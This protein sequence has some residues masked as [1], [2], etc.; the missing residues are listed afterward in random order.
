MNIT[1]VVEN[2]NCGGLERMVIELAKAQRAAGHRCQVVCVFERGTLAVELD[3]VG[4]PVTACG[5]RRGLDLRAL[6]R[7]RRAVAGHA[8]QIL[9]TH[10]A[11]AHYLAVLA[12]LG[13]PIARIINT[14]HGMAVSQAMSRRE[15][16]YHRAL[17][18]T[19][20]VAMVCAAARE[21][22]V[23]HGLVP[24]RLAHVVPNGIRIEAFA[25]ADA[26]SRERLHETLGLAPGARV[27]GTVGR[28]NWAKN[29]VSLIRAFARVQAE[30]ADAVLVLVGAGRLRQE[31]EQCARAEGVERQVHFLGARGDVRDLLPGFDVF[32][33]SSV[34][35]GYSMALLEASASGL[36]IVATDVGGNR[37]I[38]R[39]GVTGCLVPARDDAALAAALLA[40]LRD[41]ARVQRL[42]AAA[43]RWALT[44]GSLQAM[45][46]R[47]EAL[48][49]D[50]PE[51]ACA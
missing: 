19:D 15:W 12:T 7:L 33:L 4:I 22:A 44:E 18:R 24:E 20:A 9:H 1:H 30:L 23:R 42:G 48:Y 39:D 17:A 51:Y 2:L 29:Q 47:Y 14:R 10:N 21:D 3:A 6:R 5:K 11:A 36:A 28:L 46:E 27:I 43:R 49:H 25:S 45:A 31:L 37:E 16:L 8:T 26:A 34:S 50:Q 13:R 41:P 35:E 38:V 32:A 40:L